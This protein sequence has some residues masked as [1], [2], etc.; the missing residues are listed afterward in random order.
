M[1][2]DGETFHVG[3]RDRDWNKNEIGCEEEEQK[4][5]VKQKSLKQKSLKQ[6]TTLLYELDK[7]TNSEATRYSVKLFEMDQDMLV[8][9]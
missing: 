7:M 3:L 1:A 8:R 6:L 9:I 4:V 5:K 2:E